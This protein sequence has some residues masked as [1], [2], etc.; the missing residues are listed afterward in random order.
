MNISRNMMSC[1][2]NE[3]RVVINSSAVINISTSIKQKIQKSDN[4]A[5][6]KKKVLRSQ[7][8]I[9]IYPVTSITLSRRTEFSLHL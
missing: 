2:L 8:K 9:Y 1:Y 3:Q 5:V 4:V 7:K 6:E